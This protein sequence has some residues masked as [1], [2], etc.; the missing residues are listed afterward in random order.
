MLKIQL[1]HKCLLA[2]RPW[3]EDFLTKKVP[4]QELL[5]LR[6]VKHYVLHFSVV[7]TCDMGLTVPKFKNLI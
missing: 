4:R 6:T 7:S 5:F 2:C 1:K 3:S